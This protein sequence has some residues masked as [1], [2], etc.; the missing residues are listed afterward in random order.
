MDPKLLALQLF[1]KVILA[2][3]AGWLVM[4]GVGMLQTPSE[5]DLKD[6][7]AKDLADIGAHMKGTTVTLS[8]DP[9]WRTALEGQLKADTVPAATPGPAWVLDKRPGFLYQNRI[10]CIAHLRG[11]GT[12]KIQPGTVCPDGSPP[13]AIAPYNIF[14]AFAGGGNLHRF[15][16]AV[17]DRIGQGKMEIAV[18]DHNYLGRCQSGQ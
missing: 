17:T 10:G 16:R 5:L 8:A 4:S 13:D 6:Q 2:G 12:Y 11:G 14:A 9:G 15:I 18:S 1:D 7:L 3:F